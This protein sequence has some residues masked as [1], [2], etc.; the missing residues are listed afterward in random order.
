VI[1]R[2]ATLADVPAIAAIYA[3]HVLHGVGT[4][5]EVPPGEAEMARRLAEVEALDLPWRVAEDGA[6]LLGFAYAAPFRT[7]AAY[8][9]TVEDS[10]YVA[11]DAQRRG[12]GRATLVSVIETCA[13]AGYRQMLAVIGGSE[14]AASIGLHASLGF[15]PAGVLE[16]LGFKTGRW[17][18]VVMMQKALSP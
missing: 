3:H 13:A 5:E 12:A 15:R 8:R 9:F 14:N 6:R 7:R 2:P 11:P 10:V 18:D 17:V 1:V 16:S 4:F